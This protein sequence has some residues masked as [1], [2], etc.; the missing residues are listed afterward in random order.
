MV[1]IAYMVA[2]LYL[3]AKGWMVVLP[4]GRELAHVQMRNLLLLIGV[5]V[6]AILGFIVGWLAHGPGHGGPGPGPGP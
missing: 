3:Y 2:E 6:M 5:P 4:D 1:L